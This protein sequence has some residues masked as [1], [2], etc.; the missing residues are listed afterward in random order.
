[1]TLRLGAIGIAAALNQPS[2]DPPAAERLE[3]AEIARLYDEHSD[4][5]RRM[6][7]GVVGDW[8][9]VQDVIQSTFRKLLEQGHRAKA[10]SRKSWLFRVAYVEALAVHRRSGTQRKLF[11]RL[12]QQ[13]PQAELSADDCL[14]SAEQVAAVRQ[15]IEQLSPDLR[16][17]LRMRIYDDKSFAEIAEELN[18]PLS[19][20]LG[21]MR[22]ATRKLRQ[23]LQNVYRD[24][25]S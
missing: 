1:M 5:L 17:V 19:T 21:R 18:I 20:A 3:S 2:S 7:A 22:N 16:Q 8:N 12:S 14:A 24:Q 23:K 4:E 11:A 13:D 10:E 25:T 15:A 9:L 6:V